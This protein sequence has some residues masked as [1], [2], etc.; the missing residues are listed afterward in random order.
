[1]QSWPLAGGPKSWVRRFCQERRQCPSTQADGLKSRSSAAKSSG[2]FD[3]KLRP[4]QSILKD[5]KTAAV[6]SA[7]SAPTARTITAGRPGWAPPSDRKQRPRSPI[8]PASAR[9]AA[10]FFGDERWV[11]A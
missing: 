4:A 10:H 9:R 2:A 8:C 7:R 1:M 5:P 3:P 11:S 6:S